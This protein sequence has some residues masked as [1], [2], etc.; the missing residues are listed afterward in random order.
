MKRLYFV[1]PDKGSCQNLVAELRDAGIPNRHLHVVA[2][3]TV[4]LDDLPKAGLTQRTDIVHGFERGLAL[5]GTAGLLG[6]MLVLAFPPAGVV[7][8]GEALVAA[9]TA[10]G[11]GVGALALSLI[12]KDSH[13]KDLAAFEDDIAHGRILL[14][15]DVP[16]DELK[17]WKQL[18]LAHHPEAEI[19]VAAL[20]QT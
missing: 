5:G 4:P 12:S 7:A 14:M 1:V 3:L 2:S 10:G 15:V 16:K 13:N 9:V 20:P 8:G 18:I 19:G 11:A 17:H 6:G